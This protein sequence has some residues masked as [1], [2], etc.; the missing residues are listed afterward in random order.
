MVRNPFPKQQRCPWILLDPRETPTAIPAP[1]TPPKRSPWGW[2][3]RT[4]LG[5]TLWVGEQIV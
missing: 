5:W 1:N 3:S 4:E 2:M